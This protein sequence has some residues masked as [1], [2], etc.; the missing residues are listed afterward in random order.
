MRIGL[1]E[2]PAIKLCDQHGR[3]WTAF[4]HHEPL[5]S[6]QI[7]VAQLCALGFDVAL[8]NLKSSS[9]E[10]TFGEVSWRDLSLRKIFVGNSIEDYPADAFDLWGFTINYM[11]EREIACDFIRHLKSRGARVIVGGSDALAVPSVY[12]EAGAA[13]V[14][15][16]KSGAINGAAIKYTMGLPPGEAGQQMTIAAD[17]RLLGRRGPALSPEDWPLPDIGVSTDCLGTQYWEGDVPDSLLPIGSAIVDIGCDRKCDFCQTP[18]YKLGYKDMSPLTAVRWFARQKEAGAH[19]VICPSDQFLGRVLWD[20]GR[21]QVIDIMQGIRDLDLAVLWGN[22]LEIKKATLGRGMP[23]G[24]PTPDEALCQALWGWDGR[25]GCYNA[26]IPG[27]RP[28]FGDQAY[29]KLLPWEQHIA[30]MRAIARAGVPDITYGVIVGM[31]ND[32]HDDFARLEESLCDLWHILKSENP[33]LRFRIS[34]FAIR[35][36]PGTSQTRALEKEGLVVFDD[37][38][39]C[40][41]FWTA[42]ANTR[43]LSYEEVSDWQSRFAAIGEMEP[44]WQ[45]ITGLTPQ[46]DAQRTAAE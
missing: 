34:P 8:V 37:P 40:G 10:H 4:R 31:P 43:Y 27:E 23:G 36:L 24:D 16:D 42:C 1:V 30:L 39:I 22:G 29:D 26:Y 41:G 15:V 21:S 18:T 44:R 25:R 46:P 3:N 20:E 13:A 14:I 38:A 19:S 11:Q 35:P 7:L 9:D 6:K 12:L 45:G 2:L 17:G 32:R 33:A 28:V 5:V